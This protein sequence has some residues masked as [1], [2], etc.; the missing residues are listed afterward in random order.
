[1]DA[2]LGNLGNDVEEIEGKL[3]A[4]ELCHILLSLALLFSAHFFKVKMK[5]IN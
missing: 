1:V 5:L 4:V 2:S 3:E